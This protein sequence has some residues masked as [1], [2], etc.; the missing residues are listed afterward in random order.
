MGD[1]VK[2]IQVIDGAD[3]CTYSIYAATDD[4]F[5]VIFPNGTNV[6]FIEDFFDRVGENRAIEITGNLWK[7]LLNKNEVQGIH[8]T[9]FYQLLYKKRYYPTKKESEMV[10]LGVD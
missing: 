9:L 8:G 6:E 10:A 4:E 7:R 3:N 2:N 5:E 1:T